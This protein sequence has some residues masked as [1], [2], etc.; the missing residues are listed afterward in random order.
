MTRASSSTPTRPLMATRECDWRR[1]LA[2]RARPHSAMQRAVSTL[3]AGLTGLCGPRTMSSRARPFRLGE[4]KRAR[5]AMNHSTVCEGLPPVLE[6]LSAVQDVKTIVPGRMF[7]AR[8]TRPRFS[9]EIA[10]QTSQG[11]RLTCRKGSTVQEVYLVGTIGRDALDR[12][13]EDAVEHAIDGK[14]QAR[15]RRRRLLDLELE[16]DVLDLRGDR[17]GAEQAQSTARAVRRGVR[18]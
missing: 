13:L 10:S 8:A 15:L 3:V 1:G 7:T 2:G 11:W 4:R 14:R 9:I 17:L 18:A 12:A 16:G 6:H 5:L